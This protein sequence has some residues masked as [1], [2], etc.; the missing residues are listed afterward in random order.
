MWHCLPRRMLQ[1][2]AWDMA[3]WYS[4]SVVCM[5][6][7]WSRSLDI[8]AKNHHIPPWFALVY[9]QRRVLVF[10]ELGWVE[11]TA[12]IFH[13][14]WQ[15]S[16]NRIHCSHQARCSVV[17]M[18][19]CWSRSLDI[20]VGW[21]FTLVKTFKHFIYQ[22]LLIADWEFVLDGLATMGPNLAL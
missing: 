3:H 13:T 21:K 6:V 2:A 4:C 17:C 9:R 1:S 15:L 22:K 8:S 12:D 16:T 14:R 18:S 10:Q 19:V 20:G 11:L 5:S 7:C